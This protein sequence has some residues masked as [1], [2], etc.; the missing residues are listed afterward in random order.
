MHADLR[1][2]A[3][4]DAATV[5]GGMLDAQN[6]ELAPTAHRQAVQAN[7]VAH[8]SHQL[9]L[10]DLAIDEITEVETLGAVWQ[11]LVVCREAIRGCR[12]GAVPVDLQAGLITKHCV[13]GP[14]N[15][16]PTDESQHRQ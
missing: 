1:Q 12:P 9:V 15:Q 2:T 8:R 6:V 4:C 5:R 3:N 7:C 14:Y 10:H 11:R 13:F 16:D